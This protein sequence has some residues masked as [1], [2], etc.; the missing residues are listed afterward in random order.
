MKGESLVVQ[1]ELR[2]SCGSGVCR[3]AVDGGVGCDVGPGEDVGA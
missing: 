2:R 1:G 3:A